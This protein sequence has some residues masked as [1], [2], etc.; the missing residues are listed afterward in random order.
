MNIDVRNAVDTQTTRADHRRSYGT[1]V[2]RRTNVPGPSP[3]ELRRV[4]VLARHL[5]RAWGE[6]GTTRFC[7]CR[8]ARRALV[9]RST[10]RR[11]AG[12]SPRSTRTTS[13]ASF[14]WARATAVPRFPNP[15]AEGSTP[16]EL[17]SARPAT[18]RD[19]STL[20]TAEASSSRPAPPGFEGTGLLPGRDWVRRPGR[21]RHAAVAQPVVAPARQAGGR[22]CKSR[23]WRRRR[24]KK[25]VDV[26]EW[27][28]RRSTKPEDAGST[29]AVGTALAVAQWI[30]A[31][32]SERGGRPFESGRR[33]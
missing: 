4:R 20:T 11:F 18:S 23:R 30:R 31:P 16:S 25:H 15:M 28:R 10:S 33:G 17:A 5:P 8:Q 29:P 32:R 14:P 7:Q 1:H 13:C 6:A 26:A 3:V 22:G 19:T 21:A 27:T 24:S 9:R 12:A 2:H